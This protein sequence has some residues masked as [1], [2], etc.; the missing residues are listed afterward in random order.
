MGFRCLN[1]HKDFGTNEDALREHMKLC[2][3]NIT[4]EDIMTHSEEITKTIYLEP[5]LEDLKKMLKDVAE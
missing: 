2:C 1:C 4:A 3:G 5:A